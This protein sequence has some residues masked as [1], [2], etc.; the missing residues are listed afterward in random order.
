MTLECL[1]YLFVI[2]HSPVLLL[3]FPWHFIPVFCLLNSIFNGQKSCYLYLDSVFF[4]LW[5]LLF[6]LDVVIG[7]GLQFLFGHL[8]RFQYFD[9]SC[10][11]LFSVCVFFFFLLLV[12]YIYHITPFYCHLIRY[13]N[14][15]SCIYFVSNLFMLCIL[16]LKYHITYFTSCHIKLKAT[17]FSSELWRIL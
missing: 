15:E 10:T 1:I 17:G 13:I 2:E 8:A 4:T 6:V 5:L 7:P 12:I 9:L 11:P 14:I 16:A 3:R